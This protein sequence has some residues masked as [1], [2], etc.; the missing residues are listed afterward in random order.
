MKPTNIFPFHP[1]S[2]QKNSWGY[3]D[4]VDLVLGGSIIDGFLSDLY[5]KDTEEEFLECFYEYKYFYS[6]LEEFSSKE[7]Y[8]F[9]DSHFYK[10]LKFRR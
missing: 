4:H 1:K 3:G 10:C 9:K 2:N 5:E 6:S 8:S 7:Y